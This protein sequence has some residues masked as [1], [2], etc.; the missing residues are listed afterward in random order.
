MNVDM[1]IGALVVTKNCIVTYSASKMVVT[2]SRTCR[3]ELDETVSRGRCHLPSRCQRGVQIG[4]CRRSQKS[5]VLTLQV[6][7]S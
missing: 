1:K 5:P 4:A 6:L 2:P 3:T 7:I